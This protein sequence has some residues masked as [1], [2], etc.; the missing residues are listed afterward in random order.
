MNYGQL[1]IDRELA[2]KDPGIY[3]VLI[4]KIRNFKITTLQNNIK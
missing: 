1:A 2:I 4:I 3:I